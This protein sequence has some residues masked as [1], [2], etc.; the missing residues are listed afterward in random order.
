MNA[1]DLYVPGT[2]TTPVMCSMSLFSP[3]TNS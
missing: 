3:T 2:M 1:Y